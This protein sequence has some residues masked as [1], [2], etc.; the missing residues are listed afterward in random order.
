MTQ[1]SF[2]APRS[3]GDRRFRHGAHL[4]ALPLRK[5]LLR[6]GNGKLERP[7]RQTH[8]LMIPSEIHMNETVPDLELGY[9]LDKHAGHTQAPLGSG[10]EPSGRPSFVQIS[11]D[12]QA[13]SH[14]GGVS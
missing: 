3:N 6:E 12:L 9:S 13:V 11:H 10:A 2:L 1:L 14:C 8:R 7:N 4:L 5:Y